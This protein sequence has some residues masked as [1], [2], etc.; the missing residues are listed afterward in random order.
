MKRGFDRVRRS[1]ILLALF[2][3]IS[4]HAI[5]GLADNPATSKDSPK[6]DTSSKSSSGSVGREVLIICLAVVVVVGL[7]ILLFKL[8]QK[9]KREEQHARLL[10]LFEEDDELEVELGLRD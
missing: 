6:A 10:R 4:L 7:S 2:A 1:K 5:G 9:K 8:W 3:S